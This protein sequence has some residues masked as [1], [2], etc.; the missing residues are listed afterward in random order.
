L[1]YHAAFLEVKKK[2]NC[3]QEKREG[4]KKEVLLEEKEGKVEKKSFLVSI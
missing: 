1:A 2:K 3:E 4:E